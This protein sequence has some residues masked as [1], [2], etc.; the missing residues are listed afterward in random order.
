MFRGGLNSPELINEID[1]LCE[2][3]GSIPCE[4]DKK[5]D[6]SYFYPV[7]LGGFFIVNLVPDDAVLTYR[8]ESQL[9]QLLEKEEKEA[10]PKVMRR[11]FD[12]YLGGDW[13][14]KTY[15]SPHVIDSL[16]AI[17]LT[18][19]FLYS[20][21]GARL[22][23]KSHLWWGGGLDARIGRVRGHFGFVQTVTTFVQIEEDIPAGTISLEEFVEMDP[24]QFQKFFFNTDDYY[25][26][27]RSFD[28]G[29]SY[30]YPAFDQFALEA[31]FGMRHQTA[32]CR[33]Y[34]SKCCSEGFETKIPLFVS[35][36]FHFGEV[37]QGWGAT[38]V[39]IELD[40][41]NF[42][43]SIFGSG[44]I[45]FLSPIGLYFGGGTA[46]PFYDREVDSFVSAGWWL[47]NIRENGTKFAGNFGQYVGDLAQVFVAPP[48]NLSNL[49]WER[50]NRQ[51][52]MALP[53]GVKLE[54]SLNLDYM[55]RH[56]ASLM[57]KGGQGGFQLS[58]TYNHDPD[59]RH[60]LGLGLDFSFH[61]P[62][63]DETFLVSFAANYFLDGHGWDLGVS[64]G[65]AQR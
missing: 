9:D 30:T 28:G 25:L 57:V 21:D 2:E 4:F 54:Y 29:V 10:D 49:Q 17:E 42:S 60:F 20:L 34:Y 27:Q 61:N 38:N 16:R 52:F 19:D 56:R 15:S 26:R 50:L 5:V 47:G 37:I 64:I 7:F 12:L 33:D 24:D 40:S 22:A 11:Y 31:G 62:K 18:P 32:L 13:E 59:Y 63:R 6:K 3:E 8:P 1:R 35:S 39:G 14:G 41:P 48:H 36:A 23:A 43:A 44:S 65:V 46:Y 53:D 58:G 55:M 51:T 45:Y